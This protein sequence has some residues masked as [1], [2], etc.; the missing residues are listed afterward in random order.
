MTDTATTIVV[1]KRDEMHLAFSIP[2]GLVPDQVIQF[3]S[4]RNSMFRPIVGGAFYSREEGHEWMV[5]K[6]WISGFNVKKNGATGEMRKKSRWH[7]ELGLPGW[8]TD[9]VRENKPQDV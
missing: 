5:T 3:A 7:S 6:V 4:N 2:A 1:T 9:I 8:L